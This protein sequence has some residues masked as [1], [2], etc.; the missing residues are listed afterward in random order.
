MKQKPSPDT[1]LGFGHY[2]TDYMFTM[3]YTAG[4]GWHDPMI[5]PNEPQRFDLGTSIFHYA[6]GI[7]EGMK[8]FIQPDGTVE[9]C[10]PRGELGAH[11]PF[12]G[13]DVH[14]AV[15]RRRCGRGP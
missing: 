1:E 8:A 10:V 7:F 14:P 3:K 12:G 11:E 5:E 9:R 13:A 6:Q 4:E 15:P 2:F